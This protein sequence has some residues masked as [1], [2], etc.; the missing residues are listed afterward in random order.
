MTS[1][2]IVIFYLFS[3]AAIMNEILTLA[4]PKK[5]SAFARSF[6]G[7]EFKELTD[8]QKNYSYL[9]ILYFLWTF[10]GLLTSQ[11]IPFLFILLLCLVPTK[12]WFLKWIDSLLSLSLIIFILI[13]KFHL[14]I[15]VYDYLK[16]FL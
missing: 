1:T 7:K 14:H 2:F 15:N 3:F 16:S 9:T 6:K 12:Y 5:V 8:T 4:N 13:N 11:F 10:V